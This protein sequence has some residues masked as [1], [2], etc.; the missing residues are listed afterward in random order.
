MFRGALPSQE[1][2]IMADQLQVAL[3]ILRRKQVEARCGLSR[4]AI[5]RRIAEGTFPKP[6][7]IGEGK[8]VGWL[9]HEIDQFLAQCVAQRDER[10]A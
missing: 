8:A 3:T 4:S 6:V 5:Y 2:R 9:A 1:K 10:A 7:T